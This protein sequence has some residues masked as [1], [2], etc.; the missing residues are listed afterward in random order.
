MTR[1]IG[2]ERGQRAIG[3]VG[4]TDLFPAALQVGH[5]RFPHLWRQ[6][7]TQHQQRHPCGND[8]IQ[9]GRFHKHVGI[10]HAELIENC[11]VYHSLNG[12]S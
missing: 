10:N 4:D 9:P 11:H 3:I 2:A 6:E 1:Q 12:I 7:I 5:H 8:V